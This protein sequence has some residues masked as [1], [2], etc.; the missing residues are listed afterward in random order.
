VSKE[1]VN[2]LVDL[3]A[4]ADVDNLLDRHVEAEGGARSRPGR[5][6]HGANAEHHGVAVVWVSIHVPSDKII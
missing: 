2:T 5:N 4:N 6:T 3:Y 1:G